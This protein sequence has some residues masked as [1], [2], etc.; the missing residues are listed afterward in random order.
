MRSAL[1]SR[2]PRPTPKTAY[3]TWSLCLTYRTRHGDERRRSGAKA[4]EPFFFRRILSYTQICEIDT[5]EMA[6]RRLR[7]GVRLPR[8]SRHRH[9][10]RPLWLSRLR[11]CEFAVVVAAPPRGCTSYIVAPRRGNCKGKFDARLF[12]EEG[13]GFFIGG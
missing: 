1:L 9:G 6:S 12:W 10:V 4:P 3:S 7:R 13:L 5:Y 11:R 2:R 8:L